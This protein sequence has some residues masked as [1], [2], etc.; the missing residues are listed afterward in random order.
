M[1]KSLTLLHLYP[2]EMNLYGDRGNVLAFY[3]QLLLRDVELQVI[4]AGGGAWQSTWNTADIVFMGGGQDAQ[5]STVVED[6]HRHKAEG[7]RHLAEEQVTFLTICGGFQF[8]GH[9]YKP[10]NGEEL[11]GLS[12]LDVHT[13]AGR[14]RFIGNVVLESQLA[15]S[16]Q[17]LVG[18]ENHSGLTTLGSNV[19][20]LGRVI[21]GK[22]NNG[23]DFSEGAVQG[24]I[25]GTYLHGSLLPKNEWLTLHLLEQAWQRK[26]GASLP[27]RQGVLPQVEESL[28]E[29]AHA[30][31][32]LVAKIKEN[33]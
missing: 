18:F 6:L 5:Q 8:L 19:A 16:R 7:L 1:M 2:N 13:I 4:H 10:H 20:P 32:L 27:E 9:Y 22:G 30:E 25:I 17:T 33:R 31:A 12:L 26:Y 15:G 28:A 23:I 29:K 3:R 14:E 24:S 21:I 11:R